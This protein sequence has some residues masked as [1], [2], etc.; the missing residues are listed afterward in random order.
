MGVLHPRAR[1]RLITSNPE[2]RATPISSITR[3]QGSESHEGT[4]PVLTV[5]S[6]V[7]ACPAALSSA[8]MPRDRA[9]VVLNEQNA[10]HGRR[11][12]CPGVGIGLQ[13]YGTRSQTPI[14]RE[15]IHVSFGHQRPSTRRLRTRLTSTSAPVTAS[16]CVTASAPMTASAYVA[17]PIVHF[18]SSEIVNSIEPFLTHHGHRHG[19]V[20]RLYSRDEHRNGLSM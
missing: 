3:L 14:H 20:L 9:G 16:A 4:A 13:I 10:S 7:A 12:V 18:I 1:S 19:S 15:A 6:A 11:S 5:L 17:A 8:M 2:M